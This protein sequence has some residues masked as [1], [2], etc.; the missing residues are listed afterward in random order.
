[1]DGE[2]TVAWMR[3]QPWCNG[4]VGVTGELLRCRGLD[5]F[6]IQPHSATLG[7]RWDRARLPS[8]WVSQH[9]VSPRA[10]LI[11]T[12]LFWVDDK[13]RATLQYSFAL[14]VGRCRFV[15][16]PFLGRFLGGTRERRL[17]AKVWATWASLPGPAWMV[18]KW[19]PLLLAS[20]DED[21]KKYS[22]IT[23]SPQKWKKVVSKLQTLGFVVA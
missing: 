3:R 9:T 23:Y 11:P 6:W 18:P 15:S 12:G 22:L 21:L 10:T 19:M 13:G 1:M 8:S 7:L 20:R 2:A 14:V 4:K 17:S 16:H 5:G